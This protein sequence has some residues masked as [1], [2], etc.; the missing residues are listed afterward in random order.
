MVAMRKPA[1]PLL[2]LL[3]SVTFALACTGR[4]ETSPGGAAVDTDA[5]A[6]A[7]ANGGAGADGPGGV[8]AA[9]DATPAAGGTGGAGGDLPPWLQGR[10]DCAA[11][12]VSIYLTGNIRDMQTGE[13]ACERTI[14]VCGD[15]L[16]SEVV[17]N[18]N[19]A[20][21]PWAEGSRAALASREDGAPVC[22]DDW[23]RAKV[24]KDPCDPLADADCDGVPNDED[25][26]TLRAP[27]AGG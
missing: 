13:A 26:D 8:A 20:S 15:S 18:S 25:A 12:P 6:D 1:A 4:V 2:L 21:C 11:Q 14:L 10:E 19:T 23:E 17:Y 5:D 24:S 16:K 9:G 7:G 22:C 27:S 3:L